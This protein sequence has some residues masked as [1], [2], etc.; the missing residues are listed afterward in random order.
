VVCAISP[1]FRQLSEAEEDA[2]RRALAA[3]HPDVV[4]V[5]LGCPRQE[6]FVAASYAWLPEAVWIGIGGALDFYAG[7]RVRAPH[8]LQSIGLE[9]LVRL[10]QEPRRLWRRYLL[11]DVPALLALAPPVAWGWLV[12]HGSGSSVPADG[13]CAEGDAERPQATAET[14]AGGSDGQ[15]DERREDEREAEPEVAHPALV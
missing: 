10:A 7:R 9:W 6:R 4:L 15:A 1:P 8:V 13:G 14:A 11:R 2:H 12:R 3:C 5:A